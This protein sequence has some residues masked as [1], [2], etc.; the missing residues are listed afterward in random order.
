M[1]LKLCLAMTAALLPALALG[2]DLTAAGRTPA[3]SV[4]VHFGDLNLTTP[5]GRR[6]LHR[7]LRDAAWQVCREVVSNPVSI[8]GG[9]CREQLMATAMADI[10]RVRLAGDLPV[11]R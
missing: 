10:N 7:R 9:K 6:A 11:L 5:Q 3:P 2:A 1:N 4:A 8:E